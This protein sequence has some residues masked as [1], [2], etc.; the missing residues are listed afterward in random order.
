M[1]ALIIQTLLLMA[2]AYILGCILG[3]LLHQWFGAAPEAEVVKPEIPVAEPISQVVAAPIVA[4]DPDDLK[5]IKGIGR[6]N[7]ARLNAIDIT[8]FA[9]IAKWSKKEQADMGDRLAFPGR[10]E[11]EEWVKQAKVLAAGGVTKFSK[12]V[13]KGQVSSSSG[14]GS[15]GNLGKKPSTIASARGGK[16]DNLTLI[17]GVGNA[18]E[19]KLFALGIYHFNQVSKWNKDNE[20]WIG[21]ELGFPGRPERENWVKESKIL[22]AGGTTDHAKR[23]EAGKIKSSRKSKK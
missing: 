23:V 22:G 1:I 7:E 11:R 2:A 16:P 10:I 5:Q 18:L 19:K 14:K 20:A 8:R 15:V 17:D 12:R 13:V 21:N 9:Q 3:C 6:Q 4:A